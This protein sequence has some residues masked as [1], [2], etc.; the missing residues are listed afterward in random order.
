M[1]TLRSIIAGT[2][3]GLAINAFVFSGATTTNPEEAGFDTAWIY[4]L[5]T[6]INYNDELSVIEKE[7]SRRLVVGLPGDTITIKNKLISTKTGTYKTILKDQTIVLKDKEFFTI[8][9]KE[10][11][12]TTPDMIEG[13]IVYKS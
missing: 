5:S 10:S 7:R 12:I 13:K 2:V 11:G 3:L 8:G 9:R 4:K 1:I 6:D